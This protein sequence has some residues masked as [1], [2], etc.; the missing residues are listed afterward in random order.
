MGPRG[1]VAYDTERA[2]PLLRR[3]GLPSD[4]ACSLERENHLVNRGWVDTEIFLHVGFRRRLAVQAGVE[5]DKGQV[6][7]L[8]G[9]E[10]LL[11]ATH[12]G[13]AIQLFVRASIKEARMNVRYRVELSQT[14]RAELTMLLSGWQPGG[15]QTQ[16]GKAG[17][18]AK[19]LFS[20]LFDWCG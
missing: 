5:V 7:A 2:S 13:H 4:E 16:A 19:P 17:I 15:A 1:S 8:P 12:R 11:G 20:A 18:L 14:E 6:L 3:S 10:G 9:R